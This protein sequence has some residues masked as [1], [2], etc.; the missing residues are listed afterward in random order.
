MTAQPVRSWTSSALAD[1]AYSGA[2]CVWAVAGFT[3]AVSGLA[4]TIA[5]LPLVVGVFAWVGFAHLLRWTTYVDRGLAGWQRGERVRARYRPPAEPGLMA[6]VRTLGSDPQTWRDLAWTGVTSV[7]GFAW[8][9]AVLTAAGLVVAYVS[10][11]AW[12]WAVEEPRT[13]YGVTNLGLVTVDTLGDAAIASVL[14]LAL[15]PVVLLLGRWCARTHAGLAVRLLGPTS[16]WSGAAT[17][18]A[19]GGRA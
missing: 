2:V 11:P 10:M 6:Y 19:G 7:V 14:G 3:I 9:L 12:Y 17:A 1:L 18:G 4:V 16:E 13:E 15:V 8:G 5:L